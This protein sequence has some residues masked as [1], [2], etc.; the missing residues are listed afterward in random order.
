MRNFQRI[1][2]LDDIEMAENFTQAHDKSRFLI[3]YMIEFFIDSVYSTI[4]F[5]LILKNNIHRM[6]I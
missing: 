3:K 1:Q 6:R 4:L 2:V 5:E